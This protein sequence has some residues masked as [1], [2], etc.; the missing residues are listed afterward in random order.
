MLRQGLVSETQDFYERGGKRYS[1][2]D[3]VFTEKGKKRALA[4]RKQML[5][6]MEDF[7]FLVNQPRTK[8][9][10]QKPENYRN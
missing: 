9:A 7:S 3:I 6:Y 2:Y 8:Q 1:Y 5:K 4:L 10:P